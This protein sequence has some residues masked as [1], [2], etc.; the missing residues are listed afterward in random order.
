ML[1]LD[2]NILI[3]FLQGEQ[4]TVKQLRVWRE[5]HEQFLVSAIVASEVLSLAKLSDQ[6]IRRIE[7]LLSTMIIGTVDW[8]IARLAAYFRR[9]YKIELADAVIA[10]TAFLREAPMVTRNVKDFSRIREVRV[11]QL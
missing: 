4:T 8:P 2:S 9:T 7:G 3:Y 10:A 1:A 5:N 11:I 6:A